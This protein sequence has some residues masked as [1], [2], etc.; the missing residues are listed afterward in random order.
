MLA[1][2]QVQIHP[3]ELLAS[4]A[5]DRLMIIMLDVRSESDYNLFHIQGA[6]RTPI[7]DV[8]LWQKICWPT[9]PPTPCW[10]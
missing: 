3:G 1:T 7:E 10:W 4:M 5:D 9:P 6:Q 2:R 8:T